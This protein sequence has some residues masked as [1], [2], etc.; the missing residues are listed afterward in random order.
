MPMWAHYASNHSGFCVEYN[1]NEDI[2]FKASLFPVQYTDERID[3][4]NIMD[5]LAKELTDSVENGIKNN[6]K[7]IKIYNFILVWISTYYSCIK[8]KS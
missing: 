3:I 8:H 7:E 6:I 2:N 1:T 5:S 4:T